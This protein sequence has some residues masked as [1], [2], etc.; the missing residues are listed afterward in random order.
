MDEK[1][2]DAIHRLLTEI[3]EAKTQIKSLREQVEAI[4]DQNSDYREIKEEL[5]NLTAKRTE[6]KQI[7]NDDKEYKHTAEEMDELRFK[8]KDLQE[9]LS[10]HLVTYYNETQST[11]I[12]DQDGEVRSV[13]LTAKIGRPEAT[14]P[15][16]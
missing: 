7:L 15:S 8:L 1:T 2:E 10:H 11:Q 4:L 12:K 14:L 13:I 6:L 16:E 9:I 5:K 3:A